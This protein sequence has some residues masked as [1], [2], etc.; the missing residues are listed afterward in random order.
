[1]IGRT[2]SH[3]RI[4]REVG[5]GGM[6][7]VFA[8]EDVRLGRQV[9]IKFVPDGL[10]D[11]RQLFER[12][13]SEART[14]SALNHP[15]ICT[16]YDIGDH[17]GRPFLVMELLQG[18]TLRD[19]LMTG[20]L[21]TEHTLDLGIQVA[22]ALDVAHR[23]HIVHRDIKP[24]NLFLNERGSVKILDFGLAK[25]VS[26]QASAATMAP[27]ELT[28]AGMT[29]GTVAYM[30]PEQVTGEGLDGRS[31]IFSFGVVLYECVTGHQPFKGKT[32]GLILAEILNRTPPPP[33][34]FNPDLPLR[35]QEIIT[36]CLEKDRELRYQDSGALRT[37]LKRLKRDLES[38]Q[39][40]ASRIDVPIEA[41]GSNR[42]TIS[43]SLPQPAAPAS[44]RRGWI[45]GAMAAGAVVATA[46]AALL[47]F[48]TSTTPQKDTVES[49]SAVVR[50]A[51][52][53]LD[54]VRPPE[55]SVEPSPVPTPRTASPAVVR[56][57]EAAVPRAI[58]KAPP[59]I[60]E[61]SSAT[62]GLPAPPPLPVVVPPAPQPPSQPAPQPTPAAAAPPP[63]T[64]APKPSPPPAQA[65]PPP[66]SAPAAEDDDAVIRRVVAAYAR[67]IEAKD[68][69]A[70]R[71]V[72]PNLSPAEQRRL[73]DS[74]RAG[75]QKV[76]IT[77]LSIE[78]RG[79]SAAVK[80]RRRDT[81]TAGGRS[82][83]SETQQT[84][85]L[86]RSGAGW[87]ITEIH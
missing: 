61:T 81:L 19:R 12:L 10:A 62:A 70:F 59:Q 7:V 76:D 53:A 33:L 75:S 77:V 31:D 34:T 71:S 58:P 38:G 45:A 74:F 42:H 86:I 69:D 37:D 84:M 43:V 20:P 65:A 83:T 72:K 39:R 3:Y 78:R 23:Q 15:N 8:A 30:S 44:R 6:G 18:H 9:A 27:T 73:E 24:A 41:P 1:M 85:T 32:S 17:E 66:T 46:A 60:A 13:R 4:V 28:T 29:L 22:D 35:L 79:S 16:L 11:D 63:Q 54:E 82:Q 68:L 40:S 64:E 36:N 67:A 52:K 25:F 5:A 47:M 57:E 50:K 26:Q 14:A 56:K 48:R 80:V 2:I 51:E 21:K 49:G 55:A 87:V